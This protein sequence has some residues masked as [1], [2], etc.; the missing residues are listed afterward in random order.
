VNKAEAAQITRYH[1]WMRTEW[2]DALTPRW[3]R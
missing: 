2:G 3:R 1:S